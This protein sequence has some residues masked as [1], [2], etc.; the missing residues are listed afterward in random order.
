M[1]AQ[2]GREHTERGLSR[3]LSMLRERWWIVVLTMIVL[4]ALAYAVSL[5]LPPRYSATAVVV[6]SADDAQLASQAF[7][8]GD[9]AEIPRNIANDALILG[10]QAFA[11]RVEEVMASGLGAAELGRSLSVTADAKLDVIEVT[12]TRSDP[13]EAAAIA[14]AF[15]TQFV[16]RRQSDIAAALEQAQGLLQERIDSLPE[17]EASSAYGIALKQR[18]D[19]LAVLLSL[20]VSDYSV[21]EEAAVPE[22]ASFPNTLLNV[23][24]GLLAG[25]VVGL[26]AL[27]VLSRRDRRSK[28]KA[29]LERIMELPV[30]AST[31][32]VGRKSR[33]SSA[34]DNPAIGF[35]EGNEVLLES[36][37]ML[38][39]NLK[40][41]GFGE[42]TRTLLITSATPGEGRSTLAASLAISMTLAGD[43]VVLVDADLRNPS[44]HKYLGIPNTHGLTD[45]FLDRTSS[46]MDKIQAVDLRSLISPHIELARDPSGKNAPVTK[47]VCLTSGPPV[48]NPS[49]VMESGAIAGVLAE[50]KGITDYVIVDG[51]PLLTTSDAL[52]LARSVDA[53]VLA[54]GLGRETSEDALQV[55]QLLEQAELTALGVVVCG[56]KPGTRE[57]HYY[58]PHP[59]EPEE[60]LLF[61][62]S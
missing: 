9:T 46:W 4:G 41:L 8:S 49:E 57:A 54:S 10:S 40:V 21:L 29:T 55:K 43:R 60:E 37:R 26:S 30:I 42:T 45:V 56:A 23:G 18:F 62:E 31:P 13:R 39:S 47:F 7:S 19:D 6:Y 11:E 24:I 34:G 51:P 50:L 32:K 52:V 36:M 28:S 48:G 58:D 2:T 16:E 61:E 38:R 25:L 33:G 20:R 14:N 35:R 15:A 5:V 27:A 53:L 17:E 22:S 59:S 44:L 1:R 12:S 3:L